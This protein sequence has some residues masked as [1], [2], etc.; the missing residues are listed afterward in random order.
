VALPLGER[1]CGDV[2]RRVVGRFFELFFDRFVA[3]FPSFEVGQR[4]NISTKIKL[5]SV[6][7]VP[8]L[9]VKCGRFF[10]LAVGKILVRKVRIDLRVGDFQE[11][12]AAKSKKLGAFFIERKK[13]KSVF[14][15]QN[16]GDFGEIFEL[17]KNR[18]PLNP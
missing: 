15:P 2:N 11:K 9:L 13:S 7:F 10:I 16:Y 5:I 14:R 17:K 1:A 8:K 18:N 6:I 4:L 3:V 12:K